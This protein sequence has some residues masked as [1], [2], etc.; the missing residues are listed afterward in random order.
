MPLFSIFKCLQVIVITA[1]VKDTRRDKAKLHII[2]FRDF[3]AR[4][5]QMRQ[6]VANEAAFFG[7]QLGLRH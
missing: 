5:A 4:V 3:W 2:N 1:Q 6:H 7:W